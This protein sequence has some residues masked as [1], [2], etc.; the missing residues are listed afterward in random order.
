MGAQ[1]RVTALAAYHPR[2]RAG[3][4]GAGVYFEPVRTGD[5]ASAVRDFAERFFARTAWHGQ[6]AFDAILTPDSGLLP[7]ECNPRTTSGVHFFTD[8]PGFVAAL[9][10]RGE[11]RAGAA[12]LHVGPAMWTYGLRAA[13]GR[14][15]GAARWWHD[16]R[17]AGSALAYGRGR[18]WGTM[19]CTAEIASSAI[20]LRQSLIEASTWDIEWNSVT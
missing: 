14:P 6:A 20:R 8:G 10:G 7:I 19:A 16:L 1:G 11:A 17:H 12:P 2:H 15:G 3:R 5:V 4:G 9:L 18:L 13:L